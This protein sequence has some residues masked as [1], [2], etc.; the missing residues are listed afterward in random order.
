MGKK[1]R[2]ESSAQAPEPPKAAREIVEEQAPEA[3]QPGE[4]VQLGATGESGGQT[5]NGKIAELEAQIV[6][7]K[8]QYLRKIAEFE[9]FRKRMFRDK[10]EAID[11]ANKNLL[12]DLIAIIDDLERAV[13]SAE[14]PASGDEAAEFKALSEGVGMIEK[15]LVSMLEN[16]WALKRFES[17]GELFDPNRHEA[18]MVD[19]SADVEEATVG[20]DLV[21]G[22]TLKD[23]VIRAAKVKVLMPESAVADQ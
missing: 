10:Q 18:L 1:T 19:K 16:K 22:Y 20:E 5:T 12:L 21:K 2:N 7:L 6:D 15:R 4:E 14:I 9:N 17:T 3:G 13:K 8:D 23:R 11:F